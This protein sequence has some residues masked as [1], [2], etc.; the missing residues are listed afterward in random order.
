MGSASTDL[1]V[2]WASEVA[3]GPIYQIYGITI[4]FDYLQDN[5]QNSS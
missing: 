3:P 4:R 1:M 2:L 5:P